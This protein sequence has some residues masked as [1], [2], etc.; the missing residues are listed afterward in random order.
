[1]L[2]CDAVGGGRVVAADAR[3]FRRGHRQRVIGVKEDEFRAKF[4]GLRKSKGE[5]RL[6]E[7]K[8]GGKEDGGGF[9]PS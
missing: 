9:A 1:M 5:C 4:D 8:L 2:Q 7:G 3:G 6:I